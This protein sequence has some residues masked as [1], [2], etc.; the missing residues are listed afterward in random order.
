MLPFLSRGSPPEPVTLPGRLLGRAAE[1]GIQLRDG[2]PPARLFPRLAPRPALGLGPVLGRI[3]SL[4]VRLAT[5]PREV[6]RAQRLRYRVFYEEMAAVPSIAALRKR[7]DVDEYD[8]VCDHLLVIDH[9]AREVRPFRKPRP[10]V[11]GTYRLLRQ[12][13]ADRAFGFYSAG[14]YE[15]GPIL[16]ANPGRRVLELGRSCVLKP[17]RTKRTVELL[18]HGIWTYVLHHRVDAM[19]GC[20]SLEGTDPDR[21]AL[22]LSFLH[23]FARAPEAWRARALP[24]RHVPMDRLSREAIDPKAALHALPPL[25]K[26]YLRVGAT[27]GDGA[28]VDRQFGTTD[29][30][31]VLPVEAIAPRYVGHFGAGADRHAARGAVSPE[32]HAPAP[33]AGPP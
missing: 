20:A 5:A 32:C 31:V 19:L 4:E 8:A 27:F 17:Y 29:V 11:V 7:R 2:A 10:L 21:L 12:D 24:G 23:H 18:W 1:G 16:D 30:F 28:V 22:P 9:A 14:E 3:G 15:L 6:K 13:Q 26:G 25:I 33:P